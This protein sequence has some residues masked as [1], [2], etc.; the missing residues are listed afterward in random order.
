MHRSVH[1][2]L[3]LVLTGMLTQTSA[4]CA[5]PHAGE[6]E[7][8]RPREAA[9][10]SRPR[11]TDAFP[12]GTA[13]SAVEFWHD[14]PELMP[15][16]LV[17]STLLI[18]AAGAGASSISVP[19]GPVREPLVLVLTCERP[20][21]YRISLVAQET[22]E[23]LT[24]TGGESCGGPSIALF[25]TPPLDL[26]STTAVIDVDVDVPSDTAYFLAV[27]RTSPDLVVPSCHCSDRRHAARTLS[28]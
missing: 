1:T 27:Y 17:G 2:M 9:P 16:V 26:A 12:E 25:T 20:A 22:S 15:Q 11:V 5:P 21:A 19:A 24:S 14:N 6:D 18:D 8:D 28:L 3:V 7:P 13:Q 10:T 23:A 4:G